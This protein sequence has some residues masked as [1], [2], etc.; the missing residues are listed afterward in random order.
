[1]L[2]LRTELGD[3]SLGHCSLHLSQGGFVLSRTF[4]GQCDMH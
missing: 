4:L 2:T 1:M 3:L